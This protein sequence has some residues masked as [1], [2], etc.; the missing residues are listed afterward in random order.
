MTNFLENYR[1]SLFNQPAVDTKPNSQSNNKICSQYLHT[2]KYVA[3]CQ[4]E[5]FTNFDSNA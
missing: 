3:V 5:I 2:R 4:H 1:F